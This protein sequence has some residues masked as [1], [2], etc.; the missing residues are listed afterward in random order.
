MARV[1]A[2]EVGGRWFKSN[3]PD[4]LEQEMK[5]ELFD[6]VLVGTGIL[7]AALPGVCFVYCVE[8]RRKWAMEMAEHL[9]RFPVGPFH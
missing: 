8:R 1:P 7:L 5:M 4:Q 6:V 9:A 2:L 3:H